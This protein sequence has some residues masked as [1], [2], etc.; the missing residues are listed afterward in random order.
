MMQR[1]MMSLA[2]FFIYF[3]AAF[4]LWAIGTQF[5]DRPLQALL[6]FPFGLRIGILLQSPRQYWPGVLM[7]GCRIDV[8]TYRS[9]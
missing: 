1:L 6:L 7:G 9:I 4:C 8:V 5:V 2:L 3:T